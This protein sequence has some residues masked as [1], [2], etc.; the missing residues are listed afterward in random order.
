[1]IPK[2]SHI[3]HKAV[4]LPPYF[5]FATV[6]R[7]SIVT[8]N[9]PRIVA[10]RTQNRGNHTCCGGAL[11][12]HLPSST[13]SRFSPLVLPAQTSSLSFGYSD[14]SSSIMPIIS[15]QME[16][17]Y[18]YGYEFRKAKEYFAAGEE[19]E[20]D[21]E[22]RVTKGIDSGRGGDGDILDEVDITLPTKA[23]SESSP[24]ERDSQARATPT[25]APQSL[26]QKL[27]SS[28]FNLL[29]P[30]PIHPVYSTYPPIAPEYGP[31]YVPS[32][33]MMA[34]SDPEMA[35]AF[36]A[37]GDHF[38]H[39]EG[40]EE[41]GSGSKTIGKDDGK[42]DSD[43]AAGTIDATVLSNRLA[44]LGNGQTRSNGRR[45]SARREP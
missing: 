18:G 29:T 9:P 10:N 37:V 40:R 33:G 42:V 31:P 20:S 2:I 17:D 44:T 8:V 25:A 22:M 3:I 30:S 41:S 13:S 24:A 43:E 14:I 38:S 12:C 16:K 39:L 35:M 21:T 6:A 36:W 26:W 34:V 45:E 7:P 11:D 15:H 4:P 5:H 27:T 19:D 28:F 23:Q 1:M 32:V